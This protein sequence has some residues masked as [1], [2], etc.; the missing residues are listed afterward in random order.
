[1]LY[2]W[3]CI[4]LT[5][6]SA[7]FLSPLC[8]SLLSLCVSPCEQKVCACNNKPTRSAHPARFSPDD[9]FSKERVTINRRLTTAPV[10]TMLDVIDPL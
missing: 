6:F 7:L 5:L 1:M 2:S 9:K 10:N 3:M 4:F 8:L